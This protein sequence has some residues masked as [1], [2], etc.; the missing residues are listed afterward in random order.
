MSVL[1]KGMKMPKSCTECGCEQEGFWCGVLDDYTDTKYFYFDN[2][3]HPNCPLVS[4]PKHG[5]LIDAD[6]HIIKVCHKFEDF[7]E[8]KQKKTEEKK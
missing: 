2:K 1:I 3:R 4:V 7:V 5:R 6:G 8:H